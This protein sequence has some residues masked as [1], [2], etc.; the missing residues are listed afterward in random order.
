[1]DISEKKVYKVLNYKDCGCG[2]VQDGSTLVTESAETESLR[3]HARR[4]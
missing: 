2:R 4:A 3:S 1:L